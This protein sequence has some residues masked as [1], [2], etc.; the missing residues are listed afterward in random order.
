MLTEWRD[1]TFDFG[2]YFRLKE[3]A[4]QM[5]KRGTRI[6]GINT[7]WGTQFPPMG[8][9]ESSKQDKHE[10]LPSC[11]AYLANPQATRLQEKPQQYSNFFGKAMRNSL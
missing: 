5:T 11:V 4:I 6:D 8:I 3:N 9:P 10:T 7:A 2:Q 1:H